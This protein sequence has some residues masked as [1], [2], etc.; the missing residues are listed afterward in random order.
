MIRE[1]LQEIA[2]AIRY[3][4]SKQNQAENWMSRINQT[5]VGSNEKTEEN[6]PVGSMPSET[7]ITLQLPLES[8]LTT[9]TPKH[10]QATTQPT[11]SSL[12]SPKKSIFKP[13]IPTNLRFKSP[14]AWK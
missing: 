13:T 10:K 14:K 2:E 3:L 4:T 5:E 8:K 6:L 12:K 9:P 11:L 7:S 1:E